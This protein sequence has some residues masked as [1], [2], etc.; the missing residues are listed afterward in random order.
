MRLAIHFRRQTN[1]Q[2]FSAHAGLGETRRYPTESLAAGLEIADALVRERSL[3][4]YHLLP[5]V[6]GDLLRKLGRFPEA[7]AE[8]ERAARLTRNARER[9]LLLARAKAASEQEAA[10]P[11]AS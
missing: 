3:E 5:S 2:G 6:R 11:P 8:F 7:R 4:G 10:A 9:D 1:E